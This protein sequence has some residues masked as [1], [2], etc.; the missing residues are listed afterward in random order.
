MSKL[1]R[2]DNIKQACAES[3]EWQAKQYKCLWK[4]VKPKGPKQNTKKSSNVI[5]TCGTLTFVFTN[6]YII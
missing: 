5:Y 2:M 1:V 3:H 6:N 4:Q